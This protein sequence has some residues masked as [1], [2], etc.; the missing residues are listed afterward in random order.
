LGIQVLSDEPA[1]ENEGKAGPLAPLRPK[2]IF[3]RITAHAPSIAETLVPDEQKGV[4]V[5]V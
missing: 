1:S 3:V 5:V 4:V 2:V